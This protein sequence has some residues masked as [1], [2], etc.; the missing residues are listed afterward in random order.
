MGVPYSRRAHFEELE[1]LIREAAKGYNQGRPSVGKTYLK[2]S[3]KQINTILQLEAIRAH[4][5]A[6]R[7]ETRGPQ[8]TLP[9]AA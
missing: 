8:T 1:R 9:G 6:T 3:E 2:M 7:A 5:P 4:Y